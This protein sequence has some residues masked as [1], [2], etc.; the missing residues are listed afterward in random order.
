M[1][2]A[3]DALAAHVD[4]RVTAAIAGIRRYARERIGPHLA[5]ARLDEA[6]AGSAYISCSGTAGSASAESAARA[7]TSPR[8]RARTAPLPRRPATGSAPRRR[9]APTATRGSGCPVRAR[10]SHRD[11]V[12]ASAASTAAGCARS[13]SRGGH[14]RSAQLAGRRGDRASGSASQRSTPPSRCSGGG[15]G[16]QRSTDRR[17]C[18]RGTGS[19]SDGCSADVRLRTDPSQELERLVVAAEQHVL[20]VVDELAGLAI[21]E[22]GRPSAKLRPRVEHEHALARLGQQAAALRPAKPAPT[23]TT[24]GQLPVIAR[25]AS[26]SPG[27]SPRSARAAGAARARPREHVVVGALRS[28][29]GCAR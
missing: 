7:R 22:R 21:G 16:G 13:P 27:R 26:P 25:P 5:A 3:V 12:I 10:C 1:T 15:S 23:T 6:L 24:S 11:T 9:A 2:G 17:P 28:D 18:D 8:A 19:V 4:A 14:R 29:R 20:A